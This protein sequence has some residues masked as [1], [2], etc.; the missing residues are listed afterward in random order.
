ML[1]ELD[2]GDRRLWTSSGPSAKRSVRIPA[3][4]FASS[5][6]CDTPAPPWACTASS[7]M[8]SAMF[9]A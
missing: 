3:Q 6:S 7:M 1:G 8:R 4:L 2:P 9:G 5:K